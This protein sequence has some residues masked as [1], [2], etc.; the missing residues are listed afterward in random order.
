M[1]LTAFA[2]SILLIVALAIGAVTLV[3]R[4][5]CTRKARRADADVDDITDA[6][7]AGC[8][9]SEI[10]EPNRGIYRWLR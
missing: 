1:T 10:Y 3:N 4:F 9:D 6:E 7:M 2:A 5:F 8:G